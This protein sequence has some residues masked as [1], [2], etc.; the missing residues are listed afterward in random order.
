MEP[1]RLDQPHDLVQLGEATHRGSQDGEQFEKNE[2]DVDGGFAAGCGAAGYQPPAARQRFERALESLRAD[3]FEDDVDAALA[4][5]T[6]DGGQK[7]RLAVENRFVGAELLRAPG[8]LRAA[9]GGQDS[10]MP[11]L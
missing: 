11:Q 6:P 5:Q 8:L 2:S 4:G 10:C 7:I 1:A 9:D 3:V